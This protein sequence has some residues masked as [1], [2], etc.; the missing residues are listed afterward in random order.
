[1]PGQANAADY[2]QY[3]YD[4][5]GNRTS[6]RKRDGS[7]LTFQYDSLNR[8]IL[9][10]V[11]ER[12]GLDPT[13]SR[14]VHYGYDSGDR[15]LFARFDS[16][17]GEGVTNAWDGLGRLATSTI[18]MGGTSRQLL[19]GYDLADRRVRI[20]HPDMVQFRYQFDAAGRPTYLTTQTD[21][22]V[23]A[24]YNAAGLPTVISRAN[25][26]WS[27]RYYD[28]I[29]RLTA[30]D[31]QPIPSAHGVSWGFAWNPAGQIR[32][33]TRNHN[34]AYAFA[35]PGNPDISRAHSVNGLNQYLQAG[36]A[37]F[38]H[39]ANGNLITTTPA[40]P[41]IP[42][43]YVYDVENRLVSASGAHSAQ[44]RY[45][46]LGR[47]WQLTSGAATTRFL[48]DGDALIAEYNAAGAVVK[49]YAHWIGADVPAVEYD[50]TDPS[51]PR[52]RQLF[53]NHQGTIVAA[54]GP[55]AA[56]DYRNSYD[57]W[58][59]PGTQNQG[60]FQYTGQAFLP[61]LGLYYYKARL[62][63]PTLGR[64]LQTD[65]IG[66]EDQINLYAYVG[67][68]P[69]NSADPDG[70]LGSM[71]LCLAA[72]PAAPICVGG[73][74]A[75][76]GFIAIQG[77]LMSQAPPRDPSNPPTLA[78]PPPRGHNQPPRRPIVAPIGNPDED[79]PT[80]RIVRDNLTRA[81]LEA[82]RI[83]S[84][85]GSVSTTHPSGRPWDHVTEVR[86]AQIGLRNR[87]GEI[88]RA[89]GHPR[90][91]PERRLTLTRELSEAARE[92]D[93]SRRYLPF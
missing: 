34:D 21:W 50:Y 27:G 78:G 47:L 70:E 85:G 88:N 9:K 54:T 41:D 49:R 38:V 51:A 60:R 4:A 35:L 37:A 84:R 12:A 75:V 69:V 64:F 40:A 62:Y 6:L 77:W 52:L 16:A 86:N 93:R 67:N 87:I 43:T 59:F 13:H 48:Y 76:G 26:S 29:D 33:M 23:N 30:F 89:L 25:S 31:L 39:D 61:E 53:P 65:P 8:M 5:N 7:I 28:G 82:A 32:L 19:Y 44:L 57:E 90:I 83:E 55:G 3:G 80:R 73:H 10:I 56:L 2:E 18:N 20:F 79:T 22:L 58:G 91:D 72:G 92:L 15:Q 24:S 74:V 45:D 36:P 63:S 46:P 11:P 42:T 66:Y 81:D 1:M 68:D 14:D 71:S 17:A